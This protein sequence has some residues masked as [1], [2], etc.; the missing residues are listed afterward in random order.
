MSS[1]SWDSIAVFCTAPR[2]RASRGVTWNRERAVEGKRHRA[3]PQPPA[4]SRQLCVVTH[5][6][7]ISPPIHS[8]LADHPLAALL[9]PAQLCG[10]TGFGV[11]VEVV[12]HESD[13]PIDHVDRV[14]IEGHTVATH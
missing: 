14:H 7:A 4:A 6:A 1:Q 12:A 5:P 3:C 2:M 10:V 13:I 11:Q 8:E 9:E